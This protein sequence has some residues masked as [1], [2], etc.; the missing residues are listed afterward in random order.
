MVNLKYSQKY[1]N[2]CSLRHTYF[3]GA[4]AVHDFTK[5]VSQKTH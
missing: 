5:E 3:W 4:S 1:F 2:K